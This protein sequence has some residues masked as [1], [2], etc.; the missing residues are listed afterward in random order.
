MDPNP[1]TEDYTQASEYLRIALVLLSKYKVPPSPD[2]FRMGYD[3]ASGRN[4]AL[5]TAFE[6]IAGKQDGSCAENLWRLYSHTYIGNDKAM[7]SMRQELRKIITNMQ[8]QF[9]QSGKGLANYADTL[10]HFSELLDGSASPETM[11]AEV[12]KVIEDTRATEESQKQLGQ[13]LT[14]IAAEV[15][16]LRNELE[17]VRQESLIDALTGIANRKA[18]DSALETSFHEAR[19]QESSFCIM[20]ADI[21]YFKNFNDTHGHLVGDKV[22]RF[23]ASTLKR[24]VKGKDMVARFGGEE[25]AIILPQ[26]DLQGADAVA[27]EIRK[28]VSA[29][30][31]KDKKSGNFYGRVTIS[32]GIARFTDRDLPNDLV[33]RADKALYLAKERGRDRVEQ[34]A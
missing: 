30:Q 5:R 11:A 8:G 15:A 31:L 33:Q 1:Y 23:V 14:S 6:Q 12:D 3:S 13:Q 9:D 2:N 26:T 20:L 28:T 22:L 25:F 24:C 32:I 19:E 29:G 16:T 17:Q 18:F 21:D 34:A 4:E 27:E 7:A 10:S